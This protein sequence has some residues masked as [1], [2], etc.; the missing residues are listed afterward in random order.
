MSE[1]PLLIFGVVIF[2]GLI[3]FLKE[4]KKEEKEE[5]EEKKEKKEEKIP[6]NSWWYPVGVAGLTFASIE[7][8]KKYKSI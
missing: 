7:V 6:Y 2:A 3:L 1:K 8:Y 5:K 4:E